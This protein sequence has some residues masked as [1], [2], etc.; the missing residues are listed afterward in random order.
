MFR[1]ELDGRSAKAQVEHAEIA[2][3]H[4]GNR[5]NAVSIRAEPPDDIRNRQNTDE[6]GQN[7]AKQVEDTI[8]R[9]KTLAVWAFHS[10]RNL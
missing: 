9:N 10:H 2:K 4:P 5:E 7:L 6:H 1:H 3:H 8:P